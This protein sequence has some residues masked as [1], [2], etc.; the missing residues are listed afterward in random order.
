MLACRGIIDHLG[1]VGR[2]VADP[3]EVLGDEQQV[4]RLPDVV[5]IFHHVRQQGAEDGIVEIVD[6]LVALA[7]PDGGLGIA[8]DEGPQHV[9]TM[10]VAIRAI[11][12]SSDTGSMSLAPSSSGTRLA[13]FLA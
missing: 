3:L 7:D 12:G 8:F 5:R 6:R 10:S 1:D 9:V 4:G 13:I 11:S 2:V